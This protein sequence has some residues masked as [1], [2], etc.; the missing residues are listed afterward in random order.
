MAD[1][2]TNTYTGQGSWQA[3][4]FPTSRSSRQTG[5]TCMDEHDISSK[6]AEYALEKQKIT[7]ERGKWVNN[8]KSVMIALNLQGQHEFYNLFHQRDGFHQCE[9]CPHAL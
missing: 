3:D 7:V 4:P 8:N 2:R 1:R 9:K 5:A 6:A